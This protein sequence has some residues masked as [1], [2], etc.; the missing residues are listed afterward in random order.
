MS[1]FGWLLLSLSVGFLAVVGW[2]E[3]ELWTLRTPSSAP[4]R[5]A[6]SAAPGLRQIAAETLDCRR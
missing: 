3:R 5:E 6:M 2:V 1:D 4:L